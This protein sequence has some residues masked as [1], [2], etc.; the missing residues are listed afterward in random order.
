MFDPEVVILGCGAYG[1]PL[2]ARLKTAGKQVIHLGGSTQI[3]FGIKGARWDD[4]PVISSF[5][6]E[7]WCRPDPR[8]RPTGAERVEGACYW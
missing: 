3:L 4:H 2:A 1:F 6:N 8:E 5:Y 7:A